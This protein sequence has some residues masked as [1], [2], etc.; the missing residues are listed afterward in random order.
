MPR[1][2]AFLSVLLAGLGWLPATMA[3]APRDLPIQIVPPTQHTLGINSAAFSSDDDHRF[4][5]T[6]GEDAVIKLWDVKTGRLIRNVARIQKENKYWRVNELSRDGRWLL[7][8]VADQYKIW[9]TLMGREVASIPTASNDHDEDKVY[10]SPDGSRLATVRADKTIKL[11]DAQ[12]GKELSTLNNARDAAF[13]PDGKR[14]VSATYN[15]KIEL[16]DAEVAKRIETLATSDEMLKSVAYSPS[17]RRIAFKSVSGVIRLWDTENKRQVAELQASEKSNY[18]FSPDG[19]YLGVQDGDTV[20]VLN[21]DTGAI[22]STFS[23]PVENAFNAGFSPDN[24]LLFFIPESSASASPDWIV[25]AVN[26]A[27]GQVVNTVKGAAG[28]D[29]YYG[30][31]FYIEDDGGMLHLRDLES[32]HEVQTLG[33]QASVSASAFSATG[34]R[35]AVSVA[36]SVSVLDAE[37]GQRIG[38]CPA[39]TGEIGALAFSPDGRQLLYGGEDKTIVLCDFQSGAAIRSFVEHDASIK[40]LAFSSNG[41]QILS[42]DADGTVKLWDASSG[43]LVRS[44]KGNERSAYVVAVTP[45]GRK[46]LAGTDDNKVRIWDAATGREV[47]TLRMLIGPVWA[48]TVSGDSQ[49]VAAAAY[50]ELTVKQWEIASGRELRRLESGQ[51][52]RFVTP[53]DVKY[54]GA[55]DNTLAA[56]ANNHIVL[57]DPDTGRKKLDI[58]YRDQDFRSIAFVSNTQRLVSVDDAGVVRHWD[59]TTGSLILTV[60]PFGDGEWLR[61]TPEGFFDASPNGSKHP[62]VVR[63]LE[64]YS[65]DQFYDQLYRPDL[66]REKLAGDPNGLV[67]EAAAKLDL[68][69]IIASG[70]APK[71]SIVSP[72]TGTSSRS[73]EV[74]VEAEIADQGG[75]I[76]RVEWRVNGQT[77]GVEQRGLQRLEP[78]APPPSADGARMKLTRSVV[79]ASGENKIEVVAY[80]ARNLI[81]SLPAQIVLR[82][83]GTAS[84]E[85]PRLY[86][87]SLGINSYLD[88]R[89][90]LNYATSDANAVGAAFEQAGQGLY[91][92][93][94]LTKLLDGEVTRA[95]LDQAF[96]QLASQVRVSDVFV[97]F[98]AGHGR[99]KDGHYYFIPQDFRYRDESSYNTSAL[100]QQQWQEWLS[101]IKAE[102]S[103]LIYDTCESGSLAK[104]EH[105]A[106]RDLTFIEQQ[107]SAIEKLK[108]ATGRTV[109]VAATETQ[110]A[111]EGYR[112]HGVFSYAVLEGLEKTPVD[113]DGL[114]EMWALVTYV[115]SRVPELSAQA[116]RQQQNPQTKFTGS[117]FPLAKPVAVF[118]GADSIPSVAISSKPSHALKRDA[119]IYAAPGA[120]VAAQKLAEGTM[121]TLV[122]TEH[123]WVLVAKDG[124]LLGYVAADS[125]LRLQ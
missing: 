62:T 106:T 60:I 125:L 95:R 29:V 74:A 38:S 27:T 6:S 84:S 53:S 14:L 54:S 79:L 3:Q 103:V 47:K 31:R 50:S 118:V 46:L 113:K 117:N 24:R 48:M 40:S 94:S 114:I 30:S 101:Q 80:N 91:E 22:Y 73:Q 39:A 115:D 28:H 58:S 107:G 97:L 121:V 66:V 33:G 88:G 35:V 10:M 1:L 57:W 99:T 36:S 93:V 75:G 90:Q 5:A 56:T 100:S 110:P 72:V 19:A 18:A 112:G 77:I 122:R 55:S 111:L 11:Y 32:G 45:D 2:L 82:Y 23:L 69:K 44:F 4:V 20:K 98:V 81:A 76:G 71:A 64:V 37:T 12:T 102:K 105:V 7:G 68:D 8:T 124:K 96:R 109:I 15:K 63:G 70:A 85:R 42:G 61:V 43:R 116:F 123:G 67:R 52:G 21:A 78:N 17:G 16:W 86:V 59:K 119:D 51:S 34:S 92:R 104:E 65:I 83:M 89:L 108:R 13:S 120:S 25:V 49:R 9:D 26:P 87:L 41:R